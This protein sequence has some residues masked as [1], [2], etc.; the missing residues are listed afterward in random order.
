MAGPDPHLLELLYQRITVA[1][2]QHSG[3]LVVGLCG[4]Q[5]SGK[6]SLAAALAARLNQHTI[7][8]AVLSLDDLYLTRAERAVLARDVH[9][10]LATRG[11]P[12]THDVG[13]GVATIDALERGEAAPLPRFDKGCDDRAPEAFWPSAPPRTQVLLLEGW[14]VG[15]VPEPPERLVSPVNA[16]ETHEDPHSIWRTHVNDALGG[17]Y[18]QLFARI[19]LLILLTAPGWDVVE[20][21]RDEQEAALRE[22]GAEQAMA[23]VA[24]VRFIQ[25]YERLTRWI[26]DEMPGRAD[27]TVRLDP[28]R[29]MIAI[30]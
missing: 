13:L 6:S 16:L 10:L 12:G 3:L 2:A 14:C 8:C 1:A 7:A 29:A 19:E 17:S 28:R 20:R 27:V 23:P 26:L 4:A 21:W 24:I 9:P 15:A 5:G 22:C 30:T 18:Q 25:H 11:V